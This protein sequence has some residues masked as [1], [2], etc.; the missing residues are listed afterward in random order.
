MTFEKK[1][2][3]VKKITSNNNSNGKLSK[4]NFKDAFKKTFLSDDNKQEKSNSSKRKFAKSN[5][6]MDKVNTKAISE[7]YTKNLNN[8]KNNI[9]NI[10]ASDIQS[11]V[12]SAF[13]FMRKH[14]LLIVA[15]IFSI[16]LLSNINLINK[17]LI[18]NNI[19]NI[20]T[21]IIAITAKQTDTNADYNNKIEI[22]K[23][24][25]SKIESEKESFNVIMDKK[26]KTKETELNKNISKL[27]ILK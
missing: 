17:T 2:L 21:D 23:K 24:E 9:S 26:I 3:E 13:N 18:L 27:N 6:I 15:I 10:N 4:E 16:T 11:K 7:S 12:I 8:I 5:G 20:K 1:P 22:L 14:P 19:D 25:I